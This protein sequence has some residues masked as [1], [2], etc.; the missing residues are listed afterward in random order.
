[1]KGSFYRRR[2]QFRNVGRDPFFNSVTVL[3]FVNFFVKNGERGPLLSVL[4][5]FVKQYKIKYHKPFIFTFVKIF[6]KLRTPFALNTISIAGRS[7]SFPIPVQYSLQYSKALHRFC[8]DL[9]QDKDSKKFSLSKRLFGA[10]EDFMVDEQGYIFRQNQNLL[11]SI[12]DNRA[13]MH[14]RWS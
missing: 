9:S 11:K 13:Y 1:M 2:F 14:F 8:T 4:K 12:I 10:F 6:Q 7:F 5:K 3:K